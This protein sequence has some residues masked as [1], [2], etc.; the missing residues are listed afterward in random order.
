[1]KVG[2]GGESVPPGAMKAGSGGGGSR[3]VMEAGRAVRGECVSPIAMNVGSAGTRFAGCDGS[4]KRR[5]SGSPGV[6]KAGSARG[7]R[8]W[9][10]RSLLCAWF[11]ARVRLARFARGESPGAG[12]AKIAADVSIRAIFASVGDY[13]RRGRVFGA[14]LGRGLCVAAGTVPLLGAAG[15]SSHPASRR[16]RR[17]ECLVPR[18]PARRHGPHAPCPSASSAAASW[19]SLAAS[20][21][22]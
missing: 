7:R 1:M 9:E 4:W 2:S 15:L 3:G 21:A 13:C 18:I 8:I 19:A 10:C 14:A 22:W 16:L 17:R 11:A 12:Q 20:G 5:E 6:M